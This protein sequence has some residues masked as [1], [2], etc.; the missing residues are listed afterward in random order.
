MAVPTNPYN[1]SVYSSVSKTA[2]SIDC[3]FDGKCNHIGFTVP[4]Y[5]EVRDKDNNTLRSGYSRIV[6]TDGLVKGGYF[7]YFDNKQSQFFK[8]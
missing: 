3:D 4:T 2:V 1:Y 7:L 8:Q 5:W 6:N